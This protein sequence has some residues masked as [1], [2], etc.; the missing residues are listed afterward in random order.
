MTGPVVAVDVGDV[1]VAVSV[2]PAG[3]VGPLDRLDP[4]DVG[5]ADGPVDLAAVF[6]PADGTAPVTGHGARRLAVTDPARYEPSP[7]R[8]LDEDELLLGT[9]T[10]G[11][12]EALG[13]VL[14][15]ALDR[16]G[17]LLRGTRP[18][19]LVLPCPAHWGARR[20]EVLR[21]AGSGLADDLLLLPDAA[22]VAAHAVWMAPRGAPP[23]RPIAV[24]EV[25][26]VAAMAS[27]VGPPGPDAGARVL[28]SVPAGP[29]AGGDDADE[30]LLAHV[31]ASVRAD[32]PARPRLAALV[33]AAGLPDRRR[34]QVLVDDV[35][36]A[37]ER[38]S[39]AEQ[40]SVPLPWGATA[41]WCSRRELEELLAPTVR[42]TVELLADAVAAAGLRPA[43]LAGIHLVGGGAR[44]P[45]LGALVHRRLGIPAAVAPDPRLVV[46]RGA[47]AAA[48]LSA[49]GGWPAGT[50]TDR[51]AARTSVRQG[52][53]SEGEVDPVRRA[54]AVVMPDWP[55]PQPD[56]DADAEPG[57][58]LDADLGADPT[59][60]LRFPHRGTDP[61]SVA[62]V[63][64]SAGGRRRRLAA[65]GAGGAVLVALV[66]TLLAAGAIRSPGESVQAAGAPATVVAFGHRYPLPTSW[67]PAGVD[68]AARRSSIRP[69]AAPRGPDLVAV[70]ED[71]LPESGADGARTRLVER[72]DAARAG[73]DV[74]S[75]L[76][77]SARFGGRD[78]V[79]YVQ[80]P[81][82]GTTVDW[83]VVFTA[84]LQLSVG[85]RSDAVGHDQVLAAC[86]EVVS[87]V[88]A[89]A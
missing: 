74:V 41:A 70:Q 57:A 19:L 2:D 61:S 82:P 35:R 65:A 71:P 86:A 18:R 45:L 39:D 88:D 56:A 58:D 13:V 5:C 77:A 83:Y 89:R 84:D 46:A 62:A 50:R 36:A 69:D 72:Y 34:R 80:V 40:V 85:C 33:H 79:H 48:R 1:G 25:G 76:D 51:G 12:S 54:A 32:D 10:L 20:R 8:R 78:V 60:P 73:G 81:A 63:P 24:L 29:G 27:V 49:A 4:V 75:D 59:V 28:V 22:A 55:R 3:G 64:G 11:V 7:R 68:P 14:A 44:L 38:L 9:R 31:V 37:K 23:D 43:D 47:L 26:A 16:V 6:A 87:G 66:G 42:T 67:A 52:R 15:A 53:A 30:A 17:P 21:R